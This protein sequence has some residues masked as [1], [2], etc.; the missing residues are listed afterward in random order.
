MSYQTYQL[1]QLEQ[2]VWFFCWLSYQR[3]HRPKTCVWRP[4]NRASS[5]GGPGGPIGSNQRRHH[6]LSSTNLGKKQKTCQLDDFDRKKGLC[7][8]TWYVSFLWL[9]FIKKKT[10]IWVKRVV[11]PPTHF[12]MMISGYSKLVSTIRD[13]SESLNPHKMLKFVKI[14]NGFL[15]RS[16]SKKTNVCLKRTR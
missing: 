11:G 2:T 12:S 1:R 14:L 10:K 13:Y 3:E 6:R 5:S 16:I 8:I 15:I 4:S 7:E 9:L